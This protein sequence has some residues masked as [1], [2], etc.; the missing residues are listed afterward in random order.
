MW[1]IIEA[2]LPPAPLS[3]CTRMLRE[4]IA[5]FHGGA[6][7]AVA[8]AVPH[9]R[10]GPPVPA[11]VCAELERRARSQ[12]TACRSD[13]ES[14]ATVLVLII[15]GLITIGKPDAPPALGERARARDHRESRC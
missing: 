3:W 5:R 9:N 13:H 8:V 15:G 7:R 1:V 12:D 14:H 10:V 6:N 2:N 11:V 4:R